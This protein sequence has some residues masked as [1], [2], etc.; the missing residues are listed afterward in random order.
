[1]ITGRKQRPLQEEPNRKAIGPGAG[2][3]LLT[4]H[5]RGGGLG[6]GPCGVRLTVFRLIPR[7]H[8][9]TGPSVNTF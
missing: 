3:T 5:S 4:A 7:T 6:V 2:R 8:C 9:L 1:M